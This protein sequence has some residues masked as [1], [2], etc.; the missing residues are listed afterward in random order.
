MA[1]SPDPSS[2]S[3][4]SPV[5]RQSS[6]WKEPIVESDDRLLR[7]GPPSDLD[8][9]TLKPRLPAALDTR[10]IVANSFLEIRDV[11]GKE[12]TISAGVLS[13]LPESSYLLESNT[14]ESGMFFEELVDRLLSLPMSKADAK[15]AAVFLCLY[16]KFAAPAEL[17]AAIISQFEEVDESDDP[18]ITCI[19]AQLRHL[20]IL[21]QWVSEYPGDFAHPLTR[22][23]MTSFIADL[24]GTREFA[25]AAK[26]IDAHMEGVS[27]DDDT[28]WA[29]SDFA[30]GRAKTLES[31]NSLSVASTGSST[32]I[33]EETPPYS[34]KDSQHWNYEE[35]E[36]K[37]R[38]IRHS[39]SQSTSS[40]IGIGSHTLIP[41][42]SVEAAQRQIQLLNPISRNLLTKI[43]WHQF[44]DTPDE[45][46]ARELTRIDWLMFS[47]IRPRDLVRHVSLT[48][49]ERDKCKGLEYVSRM[50][51]HFNHVAFWVANMVLLRDKPKHRA[52]ALEKF[53]GLA[54]KLRQMNNYNSLGAVT[55]GINGTA[56][57]RLSQTRDLVSPQ[58][59]KDFMRLEILMSTHKSHFAYRLAWDN[60]TSE[61]IPFLPLHRRDLVSAEEGNKTFIGAKGDRINWKKFEIMG[62]VIIGIQKS[63]RTPYPG[64]GGRNKEVE[65]LVLDTKFSKDDDELYERSIQ[66]EPS[67]AGESYRKKFNWF[68]R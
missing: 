17:L 14:K 16:R 3:S 54:W 48:S 12:D 68:Q 43:Q 1:E 31:F 49:T 34:G 35:E 63:Q 59:Q 67:G 57:Y 64:L 15:F 45:D 51:N 42:N 53:M 10:T 46:I 19:E 26:E 61:R 66:V 7:T 40:S 20:S 65:K 30:R 55:A 6:A 22:Q 21:G 44:M 58:V 60:T 50:I 18:V 47:S 38:Y 23:C 52:K 28:E 11:D 24:A 9:N 32:T 33:T 4:P 37:E 62:D 27:Q 13:P 29:C 36:I 5:V 56:V 25:F 41:V 2:P 8:P 39:K